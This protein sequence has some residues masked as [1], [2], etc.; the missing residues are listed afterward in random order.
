MTTR[1]K[2]PEV[3]STSSKPLLFV[4]GV[5][6]ILYLAAAVTWTIVTAVGDESP[7]TLFGTTVAHLRAAPAYTFFFSS[8]MVMVHLMILPIVMFYVGALSYL[9]GFIL[10]GAPR[11][12]W[13]SSLH[14]LQVISMGG[15]PT[16]ER[17]YFNPAM[18]LSYA[19]ILGLQAVPITI[20][21]GSRTLDEAVAAFAITFI[22]VVCLGITEYANYHSDQLAENSAIAGPG[23]NDYQWVEGLGTLLRFGFYLLSFALV[24]LPAIF[25]IV[26]WTYLVGTEAPDL[27]A[28]WL[29]VHCGFIILV[30]VG[31]LLVM[32]IVPWIVD[33]R[34]VALKRPQFWGAIHGQTMYIMQSV[35][36]FVQ[37]MVY[38]VLLYELLT[39][40]DIFDALE[41]LGLN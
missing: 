5:G 32:D 4:N 35:L 38:T 19:V 7:V 29:F 16:Q 28:I 9:M 33:K 6:L 10:V 15:V 26:N 21:L 37:A 17:H 12:P 30:W 13:V 34:L 36:I 23:R 31:V 11:S 14:F 1:G 18:N 24:L 22:G 20:L 41:G 39:R 40:H 3:G 25:A 8:Q 27:L 2:T